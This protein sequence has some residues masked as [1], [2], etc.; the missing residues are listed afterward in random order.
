MPRI[1]DDFKSIK[2]ALDRL[3][4]VTPEPEPKAE[5]I[6]IKWISLT[7]G[8]MSVH[9]DHLVSWGDVLNGKAAQLLQEIS[10]EDHG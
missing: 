1:A 2:A 10:L 7:P 5:E 9:Q 3:N 8:S 6:E 4:G